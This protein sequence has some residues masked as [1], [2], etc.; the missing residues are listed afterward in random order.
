MMSNS[1]PS[2]VGFGSAFRNLSTLSKSLNSTKTE[3]WG[4]VTMRWKLEKK[5]KNPH[6]EFLGLVASHAHSS[7]TSILVEELLQTTLQC[8]LFLTETFLME[9]AKR[10]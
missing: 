9:Q 3:L 10:Y 7:N 6:L 8:G 2:H 5:S 1:L 4:G